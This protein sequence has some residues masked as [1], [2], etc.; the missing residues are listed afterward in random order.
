MGGFAKPV[1]KLIG[2]GAVKQV[3]SPKSEE[4]PKVAAQMNAPVPESVTPGPTA[5][6]MDNANATSI[7]RRGR[8]NTILTSVTGVETTPQLGKKSLLG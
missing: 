4:Q 8:R 2:M 6:E 3:P 7:K 5:V 1:A